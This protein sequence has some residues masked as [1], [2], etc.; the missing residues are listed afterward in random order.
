MKV[1]PQPLEERSL[2]VNNRGDNR[3]SLASGLRGR[4]MRRTDAQRC[5]N[6]LKTIVEG[7]VAIIV[8]SLVT[9]YALI[10]DDIRVWAT[11]KEADPFFQSA[12][13]VS[14][15]LFTIEILINSVVAEDFK[16]SFFFWLDIIA[17]LSL[18]A[19]I[20]WILD[21]IGILLGS[22]PSYEA[23]DVEPGVM[24]VESNASSRIQKV[25]KSVRLIRLIRII[26]LYK[27]IVQ[28]K[29][30]EEGSQPK[31]KKVTYETT[32][33]EEENEQSLFKK[34]TDPS[35]LGK[36]LSDTITRRVIIGVLLMLM[37][38]PLLSYSENDFSS[39]Y[40]LREIFWFGRSQC[41]KAN[42]DF[43]CENGNWVTQEGWFELLRQYTNSSFA[44]EGDDQTKELL[45][46]YVP[47][48]NK[49]G[50]MGSIAYVPSQGTNSSVNPIWKQ[51]DA[52]SGFQVSDDCPYRYEEMD[53]ISFI[54]QQCIDFEI[55]GC[56]QLVSYARFNKRYEKIQ[57]A[58]LQF[59]TTLFTCFVLTIA[60]LTF[61]NDTQQIVIKPIQKIVEIIQRLAENPLK[62]PS[63][64]KK[65][66]EDEKKSQMKTQMLELTIFKISTLLQRGFGELGARVVA[67]TFTNTEDYMDLMVPGKK[68]NLVFSVF[69]IRQFT[70][71]TESLQD[72]IIVFV[73]K[74]VKIV[75]EV[76]K[77]WD[78]APTKNYGDKY[79]L[80][81]RL[82]N[83][84]KNEQMLSGQRTVP[85]LAIIDGNNDQLLSPN[86]QAA[87]LNQG[88]GDVS[89]NLNGTMRMPDDEGPKD[90]EIIEKRME[91]ADK[92]LISAVKIAVELRRAQDLQAYSRHPKI[93]P[94][95][96]SN[97]RT[98][99]T[100]GLHVGWA[101]EGAIG[102]EQKIDALFL[103]PHSQIALKIEDMCSI[104]ETTILLSED[105]QQLISDKGKNSL[106]LVDFV[107]MSERKT[108][109]KEIYTFD[110]NY[111]EAIDSLSN[112]QEGYELGG[113]V[114][115]QEFET[116]DISK[117]E[118]VS[119]M[120]QIDHDFLSFK[121]SKKPQLEEEYRKA[122]RFY[123]D[124]Q[125][126]D[127]YQCLNTCLEISPEDGPSQAMSDYIEK[128]K[129]FAPENWPGYRDVDEKEAA[130]S[131]DFIKAGFDD[132]MMDEGEE[133]LDD[134]ASS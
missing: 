62:K 66:D 14:F 59:S 91:I 108:E 21:K 30:D 88:P 40:G 90:E 116:F 8:M 67:K 47:D 5:Q 22:T 45:W 127:A 11:T 56:D 7:K 117:E 112:Q 25:V 12:L 92:A 17:T 98:K 43:Y 37:V 38:L 75:H 51:T 58:I 13:I 77:K 131:L 24:K 83:L 101:V 46:L 85:N 26:K 64:P 27:Y 95:F 36:A 28:S 121:K 4:T 18:I 29:K 99:V 103:S 19:D 120:F 16:Y 93:A 1:N 115:H 20:N 39:E 60:S 122:Y 107:V 97:Y 125:W 104:Y 68:I 94:K 109:P 84:K 3:S 6:I 110:L 53:L 134:D 70:E 132:E 48:Y 50:R 55:K 42:G 111:T 119:Y 87:N 113:L 33:N 130:P 80:T 65:D 23:V 73:N 71:T 86:N 81:W 102:T 72:E 54:P 106:R 105:L 61:T 74:I 69:R 82:P 41:S 76:A 100:F 35:K 32:T 126:S 118:G 79:L 9:V 89:V 124:K 128:H 34:E 123:L 133:E 114:K 49:D 2:L 78:G 52:C 63:P 129:N 96:G 31:K 57:E 44:N 10:G 15:A